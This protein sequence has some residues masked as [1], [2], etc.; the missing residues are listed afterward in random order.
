MHP[1]FADLG[2]LEPHAIDAVELDA[3]RLIEHLA[4]ELPKGRYLLRA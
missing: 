3:A 2:P 4:V 1:Q